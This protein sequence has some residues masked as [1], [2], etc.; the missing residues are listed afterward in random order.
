MRMHLPLMELEATTSDVNET[1]V[2]KAVENYI[3]EHPTR[4]K[5]WLTGDMTSAS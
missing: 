2:D 1:S 4:V 5:Y 3:N